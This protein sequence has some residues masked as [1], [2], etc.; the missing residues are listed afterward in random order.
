MKM[1]DELGVVFDSYELCLDKPGNGPLYAFAS[2][3]FPSH[4]GCPVIAGIVKATEAEC[5]LALPRDVS[6]CFVTS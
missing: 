2:A 1:F 4:C 5:K 3:N 6:I